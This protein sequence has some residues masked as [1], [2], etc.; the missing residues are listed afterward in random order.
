M[1]Y[2]IRRR[3][4]L[5]LIAAVCETMQKARVVMPEDLAST[6]ARRSVRALCRVELRGLLERSDRR[7]PVL[8]VG[9]VVIDAVEQA[10]APL[11][12]S[13][14]AVAALHDHDVARD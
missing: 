13:P 14:E 4:S 10:R 3:A 5:G 2:R 1:S 8:R 9:R 11:R 12:V 7:K 6:C